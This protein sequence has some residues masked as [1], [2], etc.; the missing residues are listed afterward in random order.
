MTLGIGT[1]LAGLALLLIVAAVVALPLLDRKTP[2]AEPPSARDALEAERQAIVRGIRELD[3]DRRAGKL[4]E[5]DYR[6]M[7]LALVQRGADILR[8]IEAMDQAAG[9]APDDAPDAARSDARVDAEIEARIAALKGEP[10]AAPCPS[11]GAPI[12]T[13]DQFCARC[14]HR[15]A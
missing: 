4:D 12:R 14:G 11:C 13:G 9:A 8:R 1:L 3:F 6:A 2:V 15:L 5:A 7:R 10:A